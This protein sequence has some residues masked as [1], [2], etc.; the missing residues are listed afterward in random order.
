M[1][2]LAESIAVKVRSKDFLGSRI[3]IHRKGSV[4]QMLTNAHVLRSGKPPYQIQTPDGLIYAADLSKMSDHSV[5]S[6]FKGND[7]AVLWFRSPKICY[8]VASL[9]HAST[10]SVG[11][12][13]F[14][15]GFPFDSQADFSR[16][17]F[18]EAI[19]Y[20]TP[21]SKPYSLMIDSH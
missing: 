16:Y 5:A 4:Y 8:T 3:L 20:Y 21:N 1:Q 12:E 13:V 11:N 2:Q 9:G 6:Y 14:A 15:A 19:A 18:N 17:L 7:L 10:L